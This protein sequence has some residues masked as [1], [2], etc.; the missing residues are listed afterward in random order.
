MLTTASIAHS[1]QYRVEPLTSDLLCVAT[2]GS[3]VAAGGTN[4]ILMLSND[5][6]TTWKQVYL[7]GYPILKDIIYSSNGSTLAVLTDSN[8]YYYTVNNGISWLKNQAPKGTQCI[9]F[10]GDSSIICGT[11]SGKLYK[12]TIQS[13][14]WIV[15]N[16]APDPILDIAEASADSVLVFTSR[17]LF[18][19][20]NNYSLLG[21]LVSFRFSLNGTAIP[22]HKTYDG[23]WG[24]AN[25]GTLYYSTSDISHWKIFE[26]DSVSEVLM[27]QPGMKATTLSRKKYNSWLGGSIYLSSTYE[28]ES[29]TII[30]TVN[31][32]SSYS[33]RLT[34]LYFP[35]SPPSVFTSIPV[36]TSAQLLKGGAIIAVGIDK[37]IYKQLPNGNW[38][39]LSLLTDFPSKYIN[40]KI[41]PKTY[42]YMGKIYNKLSY[43]T[44][45]GILFCQSSDNGITWK[46]PQKDWTA[47]MGLEDYYSY[48]P[49]TSYNTN[50]TL[51]MLAG[52]ALRNTF[53]RSTD[54]LQSFK[55]LT[56][57]LISTSYAISPAKA[58]LRPFGD[59]TRFFT[60]S[61][62]NEPLVIGWEYNTRSVSG[63]SYDNG[64]TWNYTFY[65]SLLLGKATFLPDN[66]LLIPVKFPDSIYYDA[67][68]FFVRK[69]GG[70]ELWKSND[71]LKTH[72]VIPQPGLHSIENIAMF[73]QTHGVG[74]IVYSLPNDKQK[75]A[76]AETFDAGKS[77]IF[78]D[79]SKFIDNFQP[80]AGSSQDGSVFMMYE[81]HYTSDG[82]PNT[83]HL[84]K[85]NGKEHY[86]V[87]V[88]T[89]R[90]LYYPISADTLFYTIPGELYRL[91]LLPI[92]SVDEPSIQDYETSVYMES[93][94]PNPV[95]S[96]VRIP[97]WYYT[98]TV[99]RED[100][101]LKC[102]DISGNQVA[103]LTHT[104]T[105][106]SDAVSIAEW[107][108]SSLPSGIYIVKSLSK[109]RIGNARIVV[110]V[111]VK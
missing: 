61:F 70:C 109:N 87:T 111:G 29:H 19:V 58:S 96:T 90:A 108:M 25:D 14:E 10:V 73:D 62:R 33:P 74:F 64:T 47:F 37:M 36:I 60:N 59:S 22:L 69:S 3:Q 18:L 4:G 63:L 8:A 54:S 39:Q 65:D 102:Y 77:W 32:D 107:D 34:S 98:A 31:M 43:R 57:D 38:K 94:Y 101:S 80:F 85:N 100:I 91:V 12:S 95:T 84:W 83:I 15:V 110:K 71:T 51:L 42:Q 104:L 55:R 79:S 24:C 9:A 76:Y 89:D 106:V 46:T 30:S 5:E 66:S 52:N 2:Y 21:E 78:I 44:E 17:G 53:F 27:V 11:Q 35:D 23:H 75:G 41:S 45:T 86:T 49:T 16:T 56:S 82:V 81:H 20:T 72:E 103:D 67:D 26:P 92:S 48:Y 7:P 68:G 88:P 13:S 93:P 1:Q 6:G 99:K 28:I 97:V 50:G 105:P 40:E